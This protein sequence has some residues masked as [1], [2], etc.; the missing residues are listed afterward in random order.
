[1]LACRQQ[2]MNGQTERAPVTRASRVGLRPASRTNAFQMYQWSAQYS[3]KPA[4]AIVCVLMNLLALRRPT[5]M[6]DRNH[7]FISVECGVG[8]GVRGV[9]SRSFCPFPSFRFQVSFL[10]S[11]CHVSA[12]A[13]K[14]DI[15]SYQTRS[16]NSKCT[17]NAFAAA[18]PGRKRIFGVDNVSGGCRCRHLEKFLGGRTESPWWLVYVEEIRR[19]SALCDSL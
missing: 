5:L 8:E 2:F 13:W 17:K 12:P 1:M 9:F 14:S 11:K 10:A 18:G 16:L 3:V 15:C 7:K 6:R 19:R 4:D